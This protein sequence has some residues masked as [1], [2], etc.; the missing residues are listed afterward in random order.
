MKLLAFDLQICKIHVDS[1]NFLEFEDPAAKVIFHKTN[2]FVEK[3]SQIVVLFVSI[4]TPIIWV[5]PQIFASVF[6]YFTTDLG[7]DAFELLIGMW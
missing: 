4:L 2:Q 3:C 6:T 1:I 5:A 7:N